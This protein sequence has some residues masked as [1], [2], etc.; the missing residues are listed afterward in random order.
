MVKTTEIWPQS[1][2]VADMRRNQN[3]CV[4]RAQAILPI[5]S[6]FGHSGE[7]IGGALAFGQTRDRQ[8]LI[9]ISI[10]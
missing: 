4:N 8:T 3:A 2:L 5:A 10:L 1:I 7:K 6:I 9:L